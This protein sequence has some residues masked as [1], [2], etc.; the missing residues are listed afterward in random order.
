MKLI[1]Q[2]SPTSCHFMSP[3]YLEHRTEGAMRLDIHGPLCSMFQIQRGDKVTEGAMSLDI[4]APLCSMF[5]IQRGHEYLNAV[6][7]G[8]VLA[9]ALCKRAF[10]VC[11]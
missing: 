3:L 7:A 6:I 2:F 8:G 11:C 4:N 10:T 9:R 1:M 5:Q